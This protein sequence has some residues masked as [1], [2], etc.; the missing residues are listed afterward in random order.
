MDR[1][2]S[3]SSPLK[4]ALFVDF[5]NIYIGLSKT[6]PQAAERFASDPAR[7]LTWLEK[8]LP[9]RAGTKVEGPRE[10]S[11]LIRRCYPNPDA[12]FRRFRSFFTSAAFS[13]IDCPS[14]TRTGKN[15]SDIYMVMD[16]LDTLNHKT[17]FDEFI[18]FSGDSDF[19]P[20]LLRLRAH[21]RRTTTLA[22]DFMPPA[23]K[24]ACDLV[25]SE[26]EFIEEAL[27]FSSE[28]NGN[29]GLA[30]RSRVPVHLLKEMAVRVY[31]AVCKDGEV[32]GADLPDI[33]KDFREFRESNNWLGF[34]TSQ[35]LADALACSEPRLQL[36]RLSA[37]TYKM[38]LKQPDMQKDSTPVELPARLTTSTALAKVESGSSKAG[39]EYTS[40]PTERAGGDGRHA[41][42]DQAKMRAQILA[43][44]REMV[45][46]S[47]TALLLARVSQNVVSRLGP[48]V[49]ESQWAGAGSFKR[50][51]QS[52]SDLGFEITSQPEPGY[53]YDPKR[54]TP[55]ARTRAGAETGS[56][57][58]G[59]EQ[60]EDAAQLEKPHIPPEAAGQI[61]ERVI[62]Q[63]N[64][65]TPHHHFERDPER[66]FAHSS[67]HGSFDDHDVDTG[68]EDYD[69]E[70]LPTLDEFVK[71]VSRVTGVP[72]LTPEQHAL[73]FRGIVRELQAIAN[74]DKTYNTYQSSKAVS[75]WCAGQGAQ[76]PRGDIVLIFKGVIYQ[77]GVRFS[78][79]PGSYTALE[80][81]GIVRDNIKALCRR[82]R[83]ELSEY[84]ER[85]LDE[86]IIG[87]LEE[88]LDASL[89]SPEPGET[90]LLPAPD[91]SH[92]REDHDRNQGEE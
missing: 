32:L 26:E 79:E 49:L 58:A 87:G 69:E 22:I 53:I 52:S 15:S 73:V 48:Q 62:D 29:G 80:V 9:N 10:R 3:P 68:S 28:G 25:I 57:P 34:G 14:L 84:E 43:A 67:S 31:E 64:H 33:L 23:Y 42:A 66:S 82:S 85:L 39:K 8:G 54:H 51:L 65:S 55:P 27:G 60:D 36:E 59:H 38:V 90:G 77:D 83:L 91:T 1:T 5:D 86:W 56:G 20:V 41:R 78:K 81:A 12:G 35:R 16:I 19:M 89:S 40:T 17:Y 21:D 11:I 6:E 30:S 72:D 4:S 92:A 24:A 74:G 63:E 76:I 88:D 7:W 45:S 13:V 71:R 37:L 44:V 75:D 46:N 2:F 50:L 70:S 47:R 61:N 18:V